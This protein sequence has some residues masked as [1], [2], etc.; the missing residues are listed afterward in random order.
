MTAGARPASAHAG[1]TTSVAVRATRRVLEDV[2][3]TEGAGHERLVVIVVAEIGR[4]GIVPV[5]VFIVVAH[6]W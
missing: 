4:I 1:L 5:V 6:G 3:A 2:A